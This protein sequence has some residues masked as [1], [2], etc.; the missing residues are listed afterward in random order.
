M[1]DGVVHI[2]QHHVDTLRLTSHN[3]RP[4]VWVCLY[5]VLNSGLWFSDGILQTLHSHIKS[6]Y[7]THETHSAGLW[8]DASHIHQ[9]VRHLSGFV[10][11][12]GERSQRVFWLSHYSIL[13][14][15]SLM[16]SYLGYKC[17]NHARK[18][19]LPLDTQQ[20]MSVI[21]NCNRVA[22]TY[23]TYIILFR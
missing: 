14:A 8:S 21:L 13:S 16:G 12:H 10:E 6:L 5:V 7:Y 11:L 2:Y 17:H 18:T 19:A 23:S 4:D 22:Y 3:N 15:G 20:M 9:F 1:C